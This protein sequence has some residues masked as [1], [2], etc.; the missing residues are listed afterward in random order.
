MEMRGSGPNR[1]GE[2]KGSRLRPGFPDPV[3]LTIFPYPSFDLL[4][5]PDNPFVCRSGDRH[6]FLVDFSLRHQRPCDARHSIR[7]RHRDQHPRFARQ[8]PGQP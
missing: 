2:L 8:H 6:R 5:F 1:P 4:T 7:Q 3:S